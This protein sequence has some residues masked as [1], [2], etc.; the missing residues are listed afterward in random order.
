MQRAEPGAGRHRPVGRV[1]GRESLIRQQ[2]DDGVQARVDRL[3]PVQ[4]R[5][6]DLAAADLTVADHSGQFDSAVA[7]QF[8]HASSL[9]VEI[10]A[11]VSHRMDPGEGGTT[12]L[13]AAAC[14]VAGHRAP[15]QACG[16]A[17]PARSIPPLANQRSYRA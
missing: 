12:R 10:Q 13:A 1:G 7:P 6:D 5:L 4:V 17:R 8:A 15:G 9:R 2:A 16:T 11:T 14:P 3:D